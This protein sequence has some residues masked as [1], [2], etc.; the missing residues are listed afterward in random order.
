MAG[1][2]ANRTAEVVGVSN[3]FLPPGASFN[4]F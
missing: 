1:V 2:I 4:P 3:L